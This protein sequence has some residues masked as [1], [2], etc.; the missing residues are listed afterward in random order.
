M[1]SEKLE[2]LCKKYYNRKFLQT[3]QLLRW[4]VNLLMG[5]FYVPQNVRYQF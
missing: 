5:I 4:M 1:E 3:L 2:E